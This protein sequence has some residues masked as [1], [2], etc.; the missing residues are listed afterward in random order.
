MTST[1]SS[2][3]RLPMEQKIDHIL[4]HVVCPDCMGTLTRVDDEKARSGNAVACIDCSFRRP[5]WEWLG[6]CLDLFSSGGESGDYR[7]QVERHSQMIE[8]FTD[9]GTELQIDSKGLDEEEGYQ[10]E[11][12]SVGYAPS[13]LAY[14]KYYHDY[15]KELIA[16]E[17]EKYL[18]DKEGATILEL[19]CGHG[20]MAPFLLKR[21][22]EDKSDIEYLMTDVIEDSFL[23]SERYFEHSGFAD[24]R[25][26]PFR[27]M[28]NDCLFRITASMSFF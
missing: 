28:A 6:G 4:A 23:K 17:I 1:V 9:W 11:D 24:E 15:T 13:V 25:L 16:S 21:L 5:V 14:T 7:D 12:R 22:G 8:N 3:T 18:H 2:Q 19:G 10:Y 26:R 27:A 20:L